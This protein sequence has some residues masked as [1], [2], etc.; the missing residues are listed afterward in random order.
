[1]SKKTV[2]PLAAAI[3]T[4]FAL[5]IAAAPVSADVNPFG[6]TDLSAG[7]QQIAEG[8]CGEGKC[9]S[10]KEKK[11]MEGKCGEGKCG[12]KKEMEKNMEGKCGAQGKAQ[13]KG[14]EGKCG[15]GKC[16]SK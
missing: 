13:K 8:K 5:S 12:G 6:M 2:T 7:Y 3:G 9:G 4:A 1:M 10:K 11:A 16:G 15:E 14:T